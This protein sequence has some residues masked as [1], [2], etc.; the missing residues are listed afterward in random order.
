MKLH[1]SSDTS[2]GQTLVEFA[3]IVPLFLLIVVGLFDVG[4]AV[5]AYNTAA[6]AARAAARVAIVN[7]DP[8]VI[9]AA[10]RKEAV[11]LG[12]TD[13]NI[14]LGACSEIFC[15]YSVTVQV[16]YTPATPLIGTLF[17]PNISSTA[18]MPVENDITP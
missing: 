3:L 18:T 4:R 5:Y 1:R 11:G 15:P 13:A 9:R 12:L 17:D 16:P 6:N 2:R 10:A 7:Q 8:A 14:T